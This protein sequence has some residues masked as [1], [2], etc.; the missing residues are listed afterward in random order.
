MLLRTAIVLVLLSSVIGRAH[1]QH[2]I[3]CLTPHQV[4]NP[5][6]AKL[7]SVFP[8]GF[9]DSIFSP[10]GRFLIHYN[11]N[12]SN[13]DSITAPDYVERARVELDSAYNF[14]IDQLGY[15]QPA[16]TR[17]AHYDIFLSPL[18]L[19]LSP[20]YGATYVLAENPLPASPSGNERRRS[21]IVID[22]AFT[23]VAY[24]TKG[25]DALR[26]TIFHEFF[27]LVQFADYGWPTQEDVYFQ[28]LSSVWMEWL[29]TPGVKDYLQ[30]AGS[31]MHTIDLPFD[32]SPDLGIYGEY[33]WDAYLT[34]RF[35]TSIVKEIWA[36][37]RDATSDPITAFGLA[38][39][40]HGSSW[41]PEYEQFGAALAQSGRRYT[42]ASFLPD[43]TVLPLDT[44]P[45]H[46]LPHDSTWSF[47][48][49][50]LS[51]QFPEFGL[52][53]DTCVAVISRDTDRSLQDNGS[54]VFFVSGNEKLTVDHPE[55]YCDTELCS[56][57]L[58]AGPDVFPNPLVVRS[59]EDF[60][61]ILASTNARQPVSTVL[62]VYS[63]GQV[64]VRHTDM[65]NRAIPVRETWN[66]TWDGRDDLGHTV[67][68]GEYIYKLRVDGALKVGKIVVVR[69]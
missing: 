32:R 18:H 17:G 4:L 21:Y 27:H 20:P 2:S 39:E 3:K 58:V 13:A 26:I 10:S 30:Y 49:L 43:A 34:H 65:G 64:L 53:A 63:L 61:Y 48:S 37:Y 35:D 60:A 1:G 24:Y 15:P 31:Y 7:L 57:P 55:A 66:A 62:D 22:N 50:A 52:G 59:S 12:A 11:A 46:V 68:S 29:S 56:T 23:D 41:C 19:I 8:T 25:F 67:Q 45:I 9:R 40:H 69:K 6:S 44:L 51:L 14:E 5:K 42:G 54:F 28:E 36:N 16:F 47:V 33:L 38:L